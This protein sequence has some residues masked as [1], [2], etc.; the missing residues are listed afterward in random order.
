MESHHLAGTLRCEATRLGAAGTVRFW[1]D[2][3]V[4]DP[5]TL[6]KCM[7]GC[8]RYHSGPMCPSRS[9]AL[10]PWEYERILRYYRW[11]IMIHTHDPSTAQN[12]ALQLESQAFYANRPFALSFSECQL[13]ETC[14]GEE[15]IPCRHPAQARPS[16]HSVGIDIFR[17][18]ETFELP[19]RVVQDEQE[20]QNWYSAV[21]VE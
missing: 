8:E 3:L 20:Q 19:L 18:A 12:I 7:Y 11:G 21:F 9:D 4:F 14:A 2:D 10:K 13:C 17:T 6:L 5:R 1:I 16:F 15:D